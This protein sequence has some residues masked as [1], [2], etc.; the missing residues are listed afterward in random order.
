MFINIFKQ[1]P[2]V[3]HQEISHKVWEFSASLQK[4]GV[5]TAV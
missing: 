4:L 3:K 2:T 5:L 1:L